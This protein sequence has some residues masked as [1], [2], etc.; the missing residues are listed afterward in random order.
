MPYMTM[1][2]GMLAATSILET[3]FKDG[4]ELEEAK[5]IIIAATEAGIYHDTGSGSNV[6]ICVINRDGVKYHRNI[7][8]K[9][10]KVFEK[11]ERYEFQRG[12]TGKLL[13]MF[14]CVIIFRGI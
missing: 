2:S 8:S 9:N 6:D 11:P 10:D 12:G 13:V 4:L 14:I 3:R 1:G 5:E 7:V